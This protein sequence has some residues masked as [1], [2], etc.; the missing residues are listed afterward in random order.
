MRLTPPFVILILSDLHGNANKDYVKQIAPLYYKYM[1]ENVDWKPDFIVIPGDI[2]DGGRTED[3]EMSFKEIETFAGRLGVD[4]N[5]V[6]IAPGNHDK[7]KN[8]KCVAVN[9]W[10]YSKLIKSFEKFASKDKKNDKNIKE[11]ISIHK[12]DFAGFIDFQKKFL[13]ESTETAK[14]FTYTEFNNTP[15][16]YL[17]HLK[18][19][20][21]YKICFLVLNSEWKY[22][23]TRI[24]DKLIGKGVF[25]KEQTALD[26]GNFIVAELYSKIKNEYPD[27]SIITIMHREPADKD[28]DW[29]FSNHTDALQHDALAHIYAASDILITGHKHAIRTQEPD[30][31]KNCVQHFNSG[32]PSCQG[33]TPS[34]TFPYTLSAIQINPLFETIELLRG[35]YTKPGTLAEEWQFIPDTRVFKMRNRDQKRSR[36]KINSLRTTELH[37]IKVRKLDEAEIT[38]T[39]LADF[40]NASILY[41]PIVWN[42]DNFKT[43]EINQFKTITYDN[44][45]HL[46]LYYINTGGQHEDFEKVIIRYDEITE[47][48]KK[49]ILLM[50]LVVNFVVIDFD[51]KFK[52][53][54]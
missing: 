13:E 36:D 53:L 39:I 6:I 3:F 37:R 32:S 22:K 33:R 25:T 7:N 31:I 34:E 49:N 23:S 46:I 10:Q 45:L 40:P 35:E 1:L 19:F 38:R 47:K 9:I 8:S 14:I 18:V 52:K 41:N 5:R 44:P 54:S 16:Q 20:P 51:I 48:L 12:N 30:M 2:I 50:K 29:S 17:S 24:R 27:Y 15:L 21:A 4:I 28:F 26:V 11:F 42:I 43:T